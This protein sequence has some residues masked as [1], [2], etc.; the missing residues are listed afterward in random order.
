MIDEPRKKYKPRKQRQEETENADRRDQE[1][2]KSSTVPSE[3]VDKIWNV[4]GSKTSL[5][6]DSQER[7]EENQTEEESGGGLRRGDLREDQ[8]EDRGDSD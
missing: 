6:Q 8:V 1:A 4:L 3:I 2:A 5:R 7:Q